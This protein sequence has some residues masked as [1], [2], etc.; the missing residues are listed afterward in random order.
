MCRRS[1]HLL[2]KF[3]Y[4]QIEPKITKTIGSTNSYTYSS[5]VHSLLYS[6]HVPLSKWLAA[7]PVSSFSF[8][9]SA[10]VK[11]YLIENVFI[12]SKSC[13]MSKKYTALLCCKLLAIYGF[14]QRI[15]LINLVINYRRKWI[16]SKTRLD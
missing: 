9:F 4:K 3:F 16:F 12:N 11:N 5:V 1:I 6:T 13:C 7:F 14:P 15:Q 2:T 8:C 10:K